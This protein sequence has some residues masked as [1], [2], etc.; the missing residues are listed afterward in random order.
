MAL[1][2]QWEN[3]VF[4][5]YF[6]EG[7]IDGCFFSFTQNFVGLSVMDGYIACGS[8]TNEVSITY[9]LL[10]FL[11]LPSDGHVDLKTGLDNFFE[12]KTMVC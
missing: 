2:K 7:Y 6:F 9:L 12:P 5:G 4:D 1:M 8:E 3:S 10:L 11:T